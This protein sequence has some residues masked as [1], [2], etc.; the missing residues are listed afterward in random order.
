MF[1]VSRVLPLEELGDP[2][3]E[4]ELPSEDLVLEQTP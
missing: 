1:A 3:C 2:C 4:G